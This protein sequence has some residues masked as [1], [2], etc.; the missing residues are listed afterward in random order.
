MNKIIEIV[1]TPTGE[2]RVET[3]G[4]TGEACREASKFLEAALG[5]PG[6]EELTRDF[7]SHQAVNAIDTRSSI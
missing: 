7:F 6:Q 1:V 2:S 5:V 3:K 4:F